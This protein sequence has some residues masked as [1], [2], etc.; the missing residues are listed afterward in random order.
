[1]KKVLAI[2]LMLLIP[3]T[4]FGMETLT[5]DE[6]AEITGQSGVAIALDDV[7]I[8]YAGS[9][10]WY[11]SASDGFALDNKRRTYHGAIGLISGAEMFYANAVMVNGENSLRDTLD[12]NFYSPGR[13]LM[14]DYSQHAVTTDCAY[15]RFNFGNS[16][17]YGSVDFADSLG[18]TTGAYEAIQSLAGNATIALLLDILEA[19]YGISSNTDAIALGTVD[20][21]DIGFASKAITIRVVDELDVISEA[22]RNSLHSLQT[23]DGVKTLLNGLV[24]GNVTWDSDFDNSP[25]Q[26][27]LDW[28]AGDIAKVGGVVI[29]LP[30]AE[31]HTQGGNDLEILFF[32]KRDGTPAD[33][34]SPLC[35]RIDYAWDADGTSNYATANTW[36]FGK[37]YYNNSTTFIL[38]G[39]IEIT[40]FEAYVNPVLNNGTP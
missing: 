9:E 34:G 18:N 20:L 38:D 29:G 37:I 36:S 1:M 19:Y 3:C 10:T 33:P 22:L 35:D 30:T 26:D 25:R 27:V 16:R 32:A 17:L 8:F 21:V 40:P 13:P 31:L 5:I 23:A 6:M 39:F 14:Y 4:A 28:A 15:G 24:A 11:Q 2:A 12:A 7:K